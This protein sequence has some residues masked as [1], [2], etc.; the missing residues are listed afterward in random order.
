[1]P[2][3]FCKRCGLTK[4]HSEFYKAPKGKDKLQSYCKQCKKEYGRDTGAQ[5]LPSIRV[6]AE[7]QGVPFALT[8]DNLPPIPD[9]CP[10][11][12]I[13][14]RRTLGFADDNSPSLDRLIPEL[15]YVPDNVAW[16][17]Y[18]ANRIKNDST[19]EELIRVTEWVGEQLRKA[20]PM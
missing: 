16:I 5:I 2:T 17:S 14:L 12:G 8:K 18:R 13:P 3:K 9:T 1:M 10:I 15:G 19:Y 7:K 4:D 11:L 6:R 20:R